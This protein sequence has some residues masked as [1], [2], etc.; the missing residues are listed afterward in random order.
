MTTIADIKAAA[1][2]D[3]AKA[4]AEAVK[5]KA[6]YAAAIAKAGT[7]I[8]AAAGIIFAV[9]FIAGHFA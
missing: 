7:H 2:A 6:L 5:I 1:E 3:I 9:G 8:A 4:E